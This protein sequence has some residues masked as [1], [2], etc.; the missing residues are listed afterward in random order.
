MG[1]LHMMEEHP[2][3]SSD[4]VFQYLSLLNGQCLTYEQVFLV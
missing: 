4:D 1:L 2:N 3:A